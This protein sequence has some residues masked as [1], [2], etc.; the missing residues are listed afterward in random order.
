MP[1]STNLGLCIPPNNLNFVLAIS[2]HLSKTVPHLTLEFLLECCVGFLKSSKELKHYCLEYMTPW[3][4]NIAKYCS[5][6]FI[7]NPTCNDPQF[8]K[9]KEVIRMLIDLTVKEVEMNASIQSRIWHTLGKVEE[10]LPLIIDAFISTAI[11]N[12]IGTQHTE[13]SANTIVTLASANLDIVAGKIISQLRRAINSSSSSPS[14]NLVDHPCMIEIAVLIRFVLMLSF[15][16]HL[17]VRQY[18]PELCHIISI[19][20]GVGS[21]IIRSSIHGL[22]INMVQSLCT[23]SNLE[24]TRLQNLRKI[25]ASFSEPKMCLIFGLRGTEVAV[26]RNKNVESEWSGNTSSDAFIMDNETL[27]G[28]VRRETSLVNVEAVVN[29]LLEIMKWSTEDSGNYY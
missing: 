29:C 10:I 21:P 22:V 11:N 8:N 25:L 12:G 15:N 5:P 24:D 27:V 26:H 6:V 19:L 23:I 14:A 7:H 1:S 3:L 18:F 4:P 13:I 2:T 16:N 20:I 17:D 9:L 28:E